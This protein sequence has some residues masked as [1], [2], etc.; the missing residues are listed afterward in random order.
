MRE[1]VRCEAS[2]LGVCARRLLIDRVCASL[3][4]LFTPAEEQTEPLIDDHSRRLRKRVAE[5]VADL[6]ELG[7]LTAGDHGLVAPSPLRAVWSEHGDHAQALWIGATPTRTLLRALEGVDVLPGE[8]RRSWLPSVARES[9]ASV[10]RSLNGRV[11]SLDAWAGLDRSPELLDVW[12]EILR[13]RYEHRAPAA[14]G[15]VD[16]S[17]LRVYV[18]NAE[19]PTQ[20]TRWRRE[21]PT[22]PTLV[23]ARQPGGWWSLAWGALGASGEMDVFAL[24]WEEALR[25]SFWLD[26][27]ESCP[28]TLTASRHEEGIGVAVAGRLPRPEHRWMTGLSQRIDETDGIVNYV[29]PMTVWSSAVERI[30]PRLGLVV[31]RAEGL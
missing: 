14:E 5:T 10:V 26:H 25:T 19:R 24:N 9:V 7:E 16:W 12:G 4:P 23:R 31:A 28:L 13:E 6:E 22:T 20:R 8:L 30:A 3:G 17:E 11:V 29:L 27:R 15:A 21:R 18:P 2:A 1:A